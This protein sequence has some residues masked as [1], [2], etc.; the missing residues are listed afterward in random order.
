MHFVSRNPENEICTSEPQSLK[1]QFVNK[2]PAEILTR[3]KIVSEESAPLEIAL[4]NGLTGKVVNFGP[5]ASAKVE[6]VVLEADSDGINGDDWTPEEFD[7]KIVREIEGR[8]STLV[9]NVHLNLKEGI[10]FVSEVSFPHNAKHM[11]RRQYKLGA[12]VVSHFNGIRVKE[13]KTETFTL[14]DYRLTCEYF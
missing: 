10:G 14:K 13:A 2:I 6:V 1:L 3:N 8:K 11:K 12:K 4:V 9:G 5:E 7:S